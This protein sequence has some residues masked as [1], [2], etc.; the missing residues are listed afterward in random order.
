VLVRSG[1]G[2]GGMSRTMHRLFLD[3][4]VPR[5][6]ADTS[7]PVLLNTWEAKYFHV[8]HANVLE[9]AKQAVKLGI[10]L[11]VLDDGWFGCRNNDTTSLGDWV[12]NATKFPQGIRGLA[13]EINELGCKF[14]LWF[15]PE[16]M[17]EDSVSL[18]V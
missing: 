9:M 6:W 12:P 14:G 11:V 4:L 8:N 7:P 10:N 5:S 3:N 17:S 18:I 2:L 13:Q 15:E 16:M 1:E